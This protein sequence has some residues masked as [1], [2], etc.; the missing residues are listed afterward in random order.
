LLEI[1][2]LPDE[3]FPIFALPSKACT[4]TPYQGT[5]VTIDQKK[6]NPSI[7][8]NLQNCPTPQAAA[9][10][11]TAVLTG[12]QEATSSTRRK[13]DCGNFIQRNCT[14]LRRQHGQQDG[15]CSKLLQRSG[16]WLACRAKT[17]GRTGPPAPCY[18]V[19]PKIYVTPRSKIYI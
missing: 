15:R 2:R 10:H 8:S 1:G 9:L 4:S 14:L 19:L 13:R 7:L 18:P 17:R 16:R 3:D 12:T 5:P 6:H 11:G